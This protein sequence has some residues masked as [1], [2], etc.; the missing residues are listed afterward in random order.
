MVTG[1][2][3]S[4]KPWNAHFQPGGQDTAKAGRAAK[5]E[6]SIGNEVPCCNMPLTMGKSAHGPMSSVKTGFVAASN[7]TPTSR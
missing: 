5:R 1:K 6:T 7:S 4:P 2:P 3:V